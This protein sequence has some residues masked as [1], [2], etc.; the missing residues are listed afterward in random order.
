[1]GLVDDK[2]D[3]EIAEE[4][5]EEDDE[6]ED[7]PSFLEVTVDSLPKL[8]IFL[9]SVLSLAFSSDC[10]FFKSYILA[11]SSTSFIRFSLVSSKEIGGGNIDAILLKVGIFGVAFGCFAW[12]RR[13]G[14]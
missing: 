8:I 2:E 11:L 12:E 1:M 14:C 13:E 7:L 5:D 6:E 4:K 3:E 9:Y 10:F